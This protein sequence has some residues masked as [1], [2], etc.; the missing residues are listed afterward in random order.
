MWIKI[1]NNFISIQNLLEPESAEKI[2]NFLNTMNE[3]WWANSTT[4]DTNKLEYNL[5]E[6]NKSQ[7]LYRKELATSE[8]GNDKFTYSFDRTCDDH[9]STCVCV[10]CEYRIFIKSKEYIDLIEA[11]TGLQ[12]LK[13][14]TFFCSRYQHGDFLSP[15]TD[16]PDGRKIAVVYN[17]TKKWKSWYGGNLVILKDWDSPEV[18]K[19]LVPS[20]NTLNIMKVENQINPHYVAPKVPHK[21]LA[22]SGWYH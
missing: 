19:T 11:V 14:G 1:Q 12:E 10:E 16:S 5:L 20:F 2:Y 13:T 8:F 18:K 17:L 21:R 3:S 15:H 9:Y 22:I 6:V 4:I 7:I